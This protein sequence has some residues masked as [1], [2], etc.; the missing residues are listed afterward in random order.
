MYPRRLFLI[1]AAALISLALGQ[2]PASATAGQSA[3][4]FIQSLGDKVITVLKDS[5]LNEEQREQTF[6]QLFVEGFDVPS[7]SR[8][9]LGRFWRQATP[10]QRSEYTQLFEDFVIRTY[11]SRFGQYSGQQFELKDVRQEPSGDSMVQSVISQPNGPP[12]RIDWRVRGSNGNYKIV[13]VVVEGYSMAI[14]QRQE[15]A[16]V[17]ENGGGKV[18]TLIAALRTKVQQANRASH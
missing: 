18:E 3:G 1:S 13:D 16:S 12:V 2:T 4:S 9:T 11:A 6:H 15:F 5:S 8:F 14:T 10:Q 7:I 17:I